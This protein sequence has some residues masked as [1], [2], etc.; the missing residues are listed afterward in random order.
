LPPEETL[1]TQRAPIPEKVKG[2]KRMMEVFFRNRLVMMDCNVARKE[3][4]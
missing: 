3:Q 4:V 1:T 2:K